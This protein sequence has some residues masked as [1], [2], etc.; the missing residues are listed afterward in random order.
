[1]NR[2]EEI[3]VNKRS[4]LCNGHMSHLSIIELFVQTPR[5]SGG[6]ALPQPRP[7]HKQALASIALQKAS[8]QGEAD[9]KVDH[10]HVLQS[11]HNLKCVCKKLSSCAKRGCRSQKRRK[12]KVLRDALTPDACLASP[13]DHLALARKAMLAGLKVQSSVSKLGSIGLSKCLYRLLHWH[14]SRLDACTSASRSIE[15]SP[16]QNYTQLHNMLPSFLASPLLN[17]YMP[18]EQQ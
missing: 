5:S 11:A 18:S 3:W 4:S 1:M 10:T 7:I 12:N 2:K 14:C 8:V 16:P 9:V 6:T 17:P 13:A 15:S